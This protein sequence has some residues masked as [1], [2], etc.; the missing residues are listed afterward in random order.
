MTSTASRPAASATPTRIDIYQEGDSTR[1]PVERR[2]LQTATQVA[3]SKDGLEIALIAGGDLWVMDTE[4]KEPRQVTSTPEEERDPAFAPKGDALW[5]VSDQ[6]GQSD[7]WKASKGDGGKDWW[8][9]TSFKLDRLTQDGEVEA[10]LKWSPD[11]SKVAYLK[12][13]GDLYVISA[14]GKDP[15]KLV[16]SF[17]APR[18]DWSPDGKWIVY[19]KADDDFNEDIWVAPVDGSKPPFNLSRHPDN[20]GNPVWSPDGKSHR[21]HRTA[22]RHRGRHLLRLPPR[23]RG[24]EDRPRPLARE[25]DREDEEPQDRRS[26]PRGGPGGERADAKADDAAKARR[27]PKNRRG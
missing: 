15:K 22:G 10:D 14:E 24:R 11:G 19:A 6:G 2:V 26:S 5:F 18:F 4:L 13:R 7:L 9:N 17:D 3:F 1:D 21:L 23:R 8:Q 12:G 27:R 16:E 25:G 20:E